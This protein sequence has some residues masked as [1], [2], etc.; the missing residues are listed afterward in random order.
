VKE[1]ADCINGGPACPAD[2]A[3]L[4]RKKLAMNESDG[5]PSSMPPRPTAIVTKVPLVF[6]PVGT[7][8]YAIASMTAFACLVLSY[9]W[10]PPWF[11]LLPTY[12]YV[13]LSAGIIALGR[14]ES[15]KN[16]SAFI[17]MIKKRSEEN[18]RRMN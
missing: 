7:I 15:N 4:C 8:I 10:T 2:L 16:A 5:L 14:I 13:F 9:W 17:D 3:C 12:L 11:V 18:K 6:N 1:L